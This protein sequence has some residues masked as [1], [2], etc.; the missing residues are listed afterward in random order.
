MPVFFG[1]TTALSFWRS[2]ALPSSFAPT[3]A[4][5]AGKVPSKQEVFQAAADLA[6]VASHMSGVVG[7][8]WGQAFVRPPYSV[9]AG[10]PNE[11]R[12]CP[13]VISRVWRDFAP[14]STYVK[15]TDRCYV[16]RPEACFLQLS[17]SLSRERLFMLG[18]ELCGTYAPHPLQ[19]RELVSRGWGNV[20]T[21]PARLKRYLEKAGG[22]H[23]VAQAR[24]VARYLAQGAASPAEAQTYLLLCLPTRFGGYGI[25]P[26]LLNQRLQFA[27]GSVKLASD[28]EDLAGWETRRPD[29]LWRKHGLALEYDSLLHH[30][31]ANE[32]SRDSRR[33][34]ELEFAD[35]HVM[36]LSAGQ[37]YDR[38]AFDK[39][40]RAIAKQVGR[41]LASA[42][43]K[44]DDAQCALRQGVL[45]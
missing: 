34:G 15:V 6:V 11:R 38:A 19:P 41:R 42:S 23:G 36:T 37:L 39:L 7:D 32:M 21:T 1:H 18:M 43:R 12:R 13:D 10:A 2:G 4:T 33:R 24:T 30:S 5:P 22:A 9:V 40:A 35:I 29:F 3:G 14:K 25:E 31:K 8:A 28:S 17:A 44:W 20:L 45:G 27:G 16:A 26:P